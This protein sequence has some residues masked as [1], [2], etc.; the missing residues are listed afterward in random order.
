MQAALDELRTGKTSLIIAHRLSTIKNA[1]RILA[2]KDGRIVEAGTHDELLQQNGVYARLYPPSPDSTAD[3]LEGQPLNPAPSLNLL[4]PRF[5]ADWLGMTLMRLLHRLPYRLQ[6]AVGRV[7]GRLCMRQPVPSQ[8][9]N[10]NL[11]LCFPEL[12]P[13]ERSSSPRFCEIASG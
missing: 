2:M 1:D 5:L 10:T 4:A 8:I 12:M 13:S 3:T 9:V 7:L 6:L 11:A